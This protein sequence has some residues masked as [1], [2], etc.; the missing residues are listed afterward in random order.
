MLLYTP[1]D[2]EGRWLMMDE[3]IRRHLIDARCNLKRFLEHAIVHVIRHRQ[4]VERYPGLEEKWEWDQIRCRL[5]VVE[6]HQPNC[7]I[8]KIWNLFLHILRC[9]GPGNCAGASKPWS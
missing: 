6:S 3:E 7:Y 4:R 1:E 9:T 2:M 5:M 8:F